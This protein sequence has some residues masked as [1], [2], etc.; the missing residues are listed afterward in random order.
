MATLVDSTLSIYNQY[1]RKVSTIDIQVTSPIFY[2]AD[3]YLL[4]GDSVGKNLYLMHDD[5]LQ[6]QKEMDGDISKICVNRNG[7][8]G[9]AISGTAFKT[10]IVMYDITGDQNFKTYLS[11]TTATDLAI[12]D[13]NEYL[14]FIEIN[15]QGASAVSSI[16][17]VSVK[18]AKS[19]PSEAII[20]TYNADANVLFLKLK[21]KKDRIIALAD[22]SVHIYS[23][24]NDE[25]ILDIDDVTYFID[26][27]LEGSNVCYIRDNT[28]GLMQGQ[29]ELDI[30]NVES[31]K[32]NKHYFQETA[33]SMECNENTVAINYG[34]Q[35]EF[36]NTSGKLVKKYSSLKN[37][38]DIVVGKKLAAICYKDKIEII[39]I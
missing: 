32:I 25:K 21:Y 23:E 24:G 9:V 4:I 3:N 27:N 19:N 11:T 12:S 35:I 38:K 7:A 14:S 31:R 1:A 33:K 29:Y 22:N 2:N 37:V 34:N 39:N 6:W 13:D 30:E 20:H 18:E 15:T 36:V 26:I 8:V 28:E 16:K 5:V 17:T 10:V